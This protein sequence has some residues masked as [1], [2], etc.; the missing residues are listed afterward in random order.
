MPGESKGPL[1]TGPPVDKALVERI[2]KDYKLELEWQR[3]LETYWHQRGSRYPTFSIEPM[4]RERERLAGSGMSPAD[5]VLR[6]QWLEDQHLAS[7][8][9]VT[10]EGLRPKN[11]FRRALRGFWDAV[12]LSMGPVIGKNRAKNYRLAVP[13]ILASFAGLYAFYYVL[14]YNSNHWERRR[15]WRVMVSKPTRFPDEV[16]VDRKESSFGA[17]GFTE[18]KLFADPAKHTSRNY[19]SKRYQPGKDVEPLKPDPKV[20]PGYSDFVDNLLERIQVLD[21]YPKL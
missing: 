5:R 18:R 15:G 1:S 16:P 2:D 8:E 14:K 17:W 12:F 3:K 10:V 19:Y 13:K 9:P 4:Q 21:R 6:K 7:Y 11:I 20:Y